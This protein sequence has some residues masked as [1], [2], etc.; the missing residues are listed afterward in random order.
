MA[1]FRSEV[2]GNASKP[3]HSV[4]NMS[5]LLYFTRLTIN[6]QYFSAHKSYNI[7]VMHDIP[8]ASAVS[9][10]SPCVNYVGVIVNSTKCTGKITILYIFCRAPHTHRNARKYTIYRINL[11]LESVGLQCIVVY[12]KRKSIT[13]EMVLWSV[14]KIRIT[15]T[16]E[17]IP[18]TD[19][20]IYCRALPLFCFVFMWT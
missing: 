10:N 7:T 15:L 5:V 9:L 14:T 20:Y 1:K 17:E 11:C 3:W 12:W 16:I 18:R 19:S 8:G 6:W 4:L 13:R 2:Q